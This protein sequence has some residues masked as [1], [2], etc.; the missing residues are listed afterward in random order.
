M[1]VFV[2]P[3]EGGIRKSPIFILSNSGWDTGRE[4]YEVT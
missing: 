4:C 2:C 1:L 3:H